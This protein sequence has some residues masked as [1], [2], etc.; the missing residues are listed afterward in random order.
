MYIYI[1]ISIYIYKHCVKKHIG[2]YKYERIWC[3]YIYLCTYVYVDRHTYNTIPYHTIPYHT[4]P[5]HTTPYHTIPYHNIALH[6]SDLKNLSSVYCPLS[7]NGFDE[8]LSP[9]S[10]SFSWKHIFQFPTIWIYF[11]ITESQIQSHPNRNASYIHPRKLTWNLKMMVSNRNLLF[12]GFIFR[13]H[14]SFPGCSKP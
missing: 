4:I 9:K 10:L 6:T 3:I 2:K 14:V 12:Q 7:S 8:N 11:H 5:Y 13:F 1:Y